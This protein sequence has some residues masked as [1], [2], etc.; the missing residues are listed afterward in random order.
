MKFWVE[1]EIG[2]MDDIVGILHL[3][4]VAGQNEIGERRVGWR[5]EIEESRSNIR[6]ALQPDTDAR[7]KGTKHL[8]EIFLIQN[9]LFFVLF[10]VFDLP[11]VDT[12][13]EHV[14]PEARVRKNRSEEEGE[15]TSG[16]NRNIFVNLFTVEGK[17]SD[18]SWAESYE[19]PP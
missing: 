6:I 11:F 13:I 15:G 14:M 7:C 8:L 17:E 4:M 16:V 5:R 12:E 9:V 1:G 2:V 19:S 10:L 3:R 18:D